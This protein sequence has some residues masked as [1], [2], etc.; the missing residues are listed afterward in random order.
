MSNLDLSTFSLQVTC[1]KGFS[2]SQSNWYIELLLELSAKSSHWILSILPI[3]LC[4][5]P[6]QVRKAASVRDTAYIGKPC[7]ET[8][9]LP[10]PAA[11]KDCL[12]SQ[13]RKCLVESTSL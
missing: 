13:L 4:M 8:L 11:C 5:Q 3:L 1:F 2:V 9:V 6:W 7:L 10:N 12:L